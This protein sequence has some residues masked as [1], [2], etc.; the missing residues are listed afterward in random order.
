MVG[1]F[2]SQISI[3]FKAVDCFY[4]EFNKKEE[5]LSHVDWSFLGVSGIQANKMPSGQPF[6]ITL[7]NL[8]YWQQSIL[9][10]LSSQLQMFTELVGQSLSYHG[11]SMWYVF[12]DSQDLLLS[13]YLRV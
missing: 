5:I 3:F 7:L 8:S 12:S 9:H 2:S 11:T 10:S 6:A 4:V 1:V 13:Q